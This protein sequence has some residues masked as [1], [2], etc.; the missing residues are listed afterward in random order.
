M[1]LEQHLVRQMAFSKATYGPGKR[2]EGVLKHIEKEVEEVRKSNG[3]ASEWVDLVILSLDG[4]TR[5]LSYEGTSQER[6]LSSEFIAKEARRM[7]V[8][9][10]NVNENRTWPDW[11]TM[12]AGKAIEHDRTGEA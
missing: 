12:S 6:I 3:S 4:L 2:T 8:D 9:K 10:Q 1:D 7:I 5:E 11:R